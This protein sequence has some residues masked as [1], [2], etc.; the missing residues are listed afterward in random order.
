MQFS[1]F[2]PIF[3]VGSLSY[4]K[5][6]Q[7]GSVRRNVNKLA[8]FFH[9]STDYLLG[10]TDAPQQSPACAKLPR[11]SADALTIAEA[12]DKADDHT[13]VVI[14]TVLQ[15]YIPAEKEEQEPS[16]STVVV[17]IGKKKA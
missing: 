13:R 17:R 8:T 15:P 3:G 4:V 12:Y 16:P 1:G 7:G 14:N 10:R 11:L 5:Y 2:R 9:V 6:E